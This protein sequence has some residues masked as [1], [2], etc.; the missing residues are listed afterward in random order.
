MW[1]SPNGGG[2]A[3]RATTI[4]LDQY[5]LLSVRKLGGAMSQPYKMTPGWTKL[6]LPECHEVPVFIAQHHAA[7]LVWARYLSML[8]RIFCCLH[9]CFGLSVS[10]V[11][12]WGLNRLPH[13]SLRYPDWS[14]VHPLLSSYTTDSPEDDSYPNPGVWGQITQVISSAQM[15]K[16]KVWQTSMSYEEI[17]PG[18]LVSLVKTAYCT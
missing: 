12:V 14:G 15:L 16:S 13:A 4:E 9:D 10:W 3:R 7:Q 5:L 6:T 18:T 1:A 8:C 2:A 17:S 11:T